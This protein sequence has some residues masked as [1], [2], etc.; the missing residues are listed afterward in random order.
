MTTSIVAEMFDI[1]LCEGETIR[2]WLFFDK[3][4]KAFEVGI[5]KQR[6]L[7][8]YNGRGWHE[9]RKISVTETGLKRSYYMDPQPKSHLEWHLFEYIFDK[10]DPFTLYRLEL[11]LVDVKKKSKGKLTKDPVATL[12]KQMGKLTADTENKKVTTM[13]I[14]ETIKTVDGCTPCSSNQVTP[15]VGSTEDGNGDTSDAYVDIFSNYKYNT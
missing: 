9:S 11:K 5:R 6:S 1:S 3:P 8:D 4:R 12:Q 7:P 10:C 13:N 2:E 14:S 15:R